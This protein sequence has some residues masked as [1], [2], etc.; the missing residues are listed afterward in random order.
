MSDDIKE[1]HKIV[2]FA[3]ENNLKLDVQSVNVTEFIESDGSESIKV[4]I[5]I[6]LSEKRLPRSIMY[7]LVKSAANAIRNSGESRYPVI[8]PHLAKQQ[9]LAARS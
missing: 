7:D 9:L 1:L 3:I 5:S 8:L 6:R 2:S 4:E